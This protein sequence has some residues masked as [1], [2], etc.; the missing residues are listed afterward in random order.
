[1]NDST[2][3]APLDDLAAV[4]RIVGELV[5]D[6]RHDRWSAPTPCPEWDVRALVEHMVLGHRLFAAILRGEATVTAGAL[7]PGSADALGDDPAGTYR[8]AADSLLAA[9]GQPGVLGRTFEVPVGPVPG[10]V[11]VHLRIVEELVHGWDLAQATG[12]QP[13]FP[14]DV[15]ER[16][17]E[18]T[19][20]KLADVP[21]ER[22]PFAPPRPVSDLAPPIDGLAALLGR[23]ALAGSAAATPTRRH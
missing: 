2:E 1:M 23:T 18:F 19:R 3:Q 14:D 8:E 11:A 5:G 22:S 10:I 4:L 17:A 13:R 20:V 6:V 21:P 7:E 12:G 16:A 15:V 9:F